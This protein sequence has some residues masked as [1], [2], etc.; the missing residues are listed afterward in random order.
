MNETTNNGR[1]I[2]IAAVVIVLAV[3]A[4]MYMGS[5]T[6]VV[7]EET[8][9]T[10]VAISTAPVTTTPGTPVVPV[11]E[12][13]KSGYKDGTYSST[14]SY[15]SPGGAESVT[16]SLTLKNGIVTDSTVTGNA[17]NPTSKQYQGMFV[18]GYKTFVTGKSIDAV[19]VSKVSGSS[20]T[21]RGFNEAL[22]K[23]KVEAKA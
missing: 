19:S 16:V 7:P 21:A 4:Y 14:G 9:E 5:S 22:A 3:I 6:P 23:I 10:P 12:A 17:E 20:L 15:T 8:P 13:P 11:T 1:L 18:A 2:G